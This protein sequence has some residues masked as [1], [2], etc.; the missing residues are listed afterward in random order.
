MRK[1]RVW[2]FFRVA[3]L[4]SVIFLF[5]SP[6]GVS[7]KTLK[8]GVVLD[9]AFPLH[10][11]YKKEL[12]A[13]VEDYNKKGGL[14][15][16]GEKYDIQLIVYDSK[17][18]AETARSAVERLIYRD[19]VKLIMGD[20]TADAWIPLTEANKILITAASPSPKTRSPEHKYVFQST[21]LNT[22]SPVAWAWFS[23][24]HPEM[25]K[26]GAVFTDDMKGHAEGKNLER[27]CSVFGQELVD[28]IY[29]PPD[30]TDFS[31]I[32]TR[33]KNMKP[34]VFTTCAGGPVQ[35]ALAT[36]AMREAGWNGQIFSYVGLNPASIKKIIS[37][38][39]VEGML[40]TMSGIDIPQPPPVSQEFIDVYMA[41]YGKWDNPPIVHVNNWYL[42]IAA[43][44]QAQSLDPDTVA[45]HIAKGMDF[46]SPQAK[47]KTVSRPDLNNPRCI[48][49]LYEVN[50]GRIR[51]GETEVITKI[52]QAKALQSLKVFFAGEK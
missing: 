11:S 41:K 23:E 7:A 24:A 51:N 36:K 1:G 9:Y 21:S 30:T 50:I 42:L 28:I 52:D 27:L 16:Q 45:S 2:M 49:T 8:I 34:H 40:G 32:A 39:Y 14:N 10:V 31:A 25:N 3:L 26:V 47:A 13:I 38:D 12:D 43:L 4:V 5:A 37:I 44:D 29:Y 20:E 48:D 15:I 22:Q 19:K 18:N 6:G 35:D 17:L 33:L 46:M